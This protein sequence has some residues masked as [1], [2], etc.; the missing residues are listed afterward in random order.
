MADFLSTFPKLFL[1]SSDE[2]I[3]LALGIF[4]VIDVLVCRLPAVKH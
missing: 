3:F 4:E 2:F 1:E